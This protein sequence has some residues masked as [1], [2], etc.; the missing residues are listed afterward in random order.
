MKKNISILLVTIM[1]LSIFSAC[2]KNEE[3]SV[4][5]N[6]EVSNKEEEVVLNY[7]TWFPNED[8]LADTISAFEKENPNIKINMTVMESKAFQEKVPLALSTEEDIDIIGVQPSAFAEQVQDY[9]V[10]LDELMPSI[11]G[12]DW[13]DN[14]S[15]K[16]F[17]QANR[18]TG[19][20]TKMLVILN[21]GAMVG[22][23]NAKLLEDIGCEVPKTIQEYKVVAD[24]FKEKYP[25]KYVSSFAGKDAWVMD[26]MMLTVLGQQSDYYNKWRYGGADVDSAEYRAAFEGFKKFFDEGIFSKDVL[27]LD[28]GSALEEFANG[29]AL[30]FYQG[31]WESPLLSKKLREAKDIKLDS[32]GAMALPVVEDGGVLTCRSYIDTALGVV[33]YSKKQEAAA[34]FVAFLTL[35]EGANIFGKQLVGTSPKK[36]FVVDESMLEGEAAKEGWNTIVQLL[37]SGTADRNNVSGYSDIEGA[38]VQSYVNGTKTLDE[39][40]EACQEEWTS[41]KY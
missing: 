13:K 27:D 14:Y 41:G 31:S 19:D 28:Y 21:S 12:D 18:L 1:M 36:D 7:W 10:D 40:I 24:K 39:A 38:E 29:N 20:K 17:E 15:E 6:G 32:V 11:I 5:N 2:G 4:G 37:D 33:S 23:Y 9:L 26:E 16:R 8:M 22:Y 25:D 30:V 34:K 35:G 3:V